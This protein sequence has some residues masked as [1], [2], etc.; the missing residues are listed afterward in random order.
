MPPNGNTK[1]AE[2]KPAQPMQI[3][4]INASEMPTNGVKWWPLF[5]DLKLRLEQTPAS[6]ALAVSFAHGDSISGV[7]SSLA[8]LF[9]HQCG[10]NAVII[11]TGVDRDGAPTL[12][13]RRGPNWGK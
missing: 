1:R 11:A 12:Y 5:L 8:R 7:K 3:R 13:V 4:E 10:E 6:K 9:K 2:P